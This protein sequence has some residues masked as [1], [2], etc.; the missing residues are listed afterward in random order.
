MP[1]LLGLLLCWIFVGRCEANKK[2]KEV[3]VIQ[4]NSELL[5]REQLA[6]NEVLLKETARLQRELAEAQRELTEGKCVI[7]REA[8]PS[9]VFIPCGHVCVCSSCWDRTANDT[10]RCPKCR[11]DVQFAF[12]AFV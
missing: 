6:I 3:E 9:R 8:D 1:T 10:S 11:Q 2:L 12:R 5:I 4:Q 7:C